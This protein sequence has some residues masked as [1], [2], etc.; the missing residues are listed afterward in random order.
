LSLTRA[1]KHV[2]NLGVRA[3]VRVRDQDHWMLALRWEVIV[4]Y[5]ELVF[6]SGPWTQPRKSAS[7]SSSPSRPTF[8][9]KSFFKLPLGEAGF[10]P[11]LTSVRVITPSPRSS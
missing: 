10:L 9:L 1:K 8:P 11:S 2:Q 6:H 5:F 4:P 7:S 3:P